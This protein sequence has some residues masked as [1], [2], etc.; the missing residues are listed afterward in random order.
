MTQHM[1]FKK[2]AVTCVIINTATM[3][4]ISGNES[5]MKFKTQ[6]SLLFRKKNINKA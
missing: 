6:F 1:L 4:T 5:Q 2:I 3:A